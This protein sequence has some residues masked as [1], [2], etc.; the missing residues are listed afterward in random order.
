M[1]MNSKFLHFEF[2]LHTIINCLAQELT[3]KSNSWKMCVM[4]LGTLT[5]KTLLSLSKLTTLAVI[6]PGKMSRISKGGKFSVRDCAFLWE[7]KY[8]RITSSIS[9]IDFFSLLWCFWFV[10]GEKALGNATGG[11]LLSFATI[12]QLHQKEAST[13]CYC[14][15]C[16]NTSFITWSSNF[17]T[18]PPSFF[19]SVP[20]VLHIFWWDLV[21]VQNHW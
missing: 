8:G 6:W 4:L 1:S 19:H 14:K 3:I 17:D 15:C 21:S 13:H 11:R 12:D 9:L 10:L 20:W 18:L 2:E 7:V 16:S 5:D